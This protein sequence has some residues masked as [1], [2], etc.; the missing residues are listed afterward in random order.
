M[1]K[2]GEK[3]PDFTLD[4]DDGKRISLSVFRGKNIVL[5]FYPKDGTPG[6]T[7]EA[8]EF[9]N[10]SR[11]F[12]NTNAVILGISKDSIESHRKFKDKNNLHFTLLS[13][14]KSEIQKLYGVWKEKSLYGKKFMGTERSTFL[15]NEKGIV[16]KI[17][18][19]VK[20][21]GHAEACLLELKTSK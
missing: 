8:V 14:P 2:E 18:R 3:A 7:Q 16:E 11:K 5:Y 21:K 9:Q 1:I 17:Y 12:G 13:D 20:V 10:L 4:S 6:C 15:I 19:K